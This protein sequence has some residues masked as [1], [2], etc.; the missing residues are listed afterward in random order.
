MSGHLIEVRDL[1]K[2]YS[3]G[4][5]SVAA[6]AGV[7]LSIDNGEFVAIFTEAADNIIGHGSRSI[8]FAQDG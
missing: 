4:E 3:L 1:K 7:S 8:F 2:I 6:L 5:E